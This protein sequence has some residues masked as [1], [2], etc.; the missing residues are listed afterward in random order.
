MSTS[1]STS[2]R[3]LQ[4][5]YIPTE[6]I[7][8]MYLALF[9][10]S[11]FAHTVQAFYFRLW[12]LM[13]SVIFC[14]FLELT[15]WS[16]RLWSSQ[17]PFLDKPYIMQ[18]VT[19]VIAPTPLVAA[20]FILLGRIIRRL[21]PQYSR[22]TPRR[23]TIIF[24]S[25]DIISLVIQALGGGIAS[26]S[27]SRSQAQAGSHIALGGTVFQLVAIIAYCALAAEFLFRYTRDRPMRSARVPG[28][29]LRGMIDKRLR[30]MLIAMFIMTD[31]I[32]IR[33][34]YRTVEFVDGWDGKVISTQWLF[35]VFDGAMIVLAMFTLNA[36][37]PGVLLL[38]SDDLNLY[39]TSSNVITL[40][41]H[42]SKNGDSSEERSA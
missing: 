6:W 24:V 7:S 3:I 25:C 38:G 22:L 42:L 39:P 14:G 13:P 2:D 28:E 9:G 37:H 33:T 19:L 35:N 8:I 40:R 18:A 36:F 10:L 21:G 12:W 26:V 27:T 17:N 20:N 15:G 23:Y 29:A 16:S 1:N 32:V 34:V 31:F 30:R 5:N 11:T 41:D 4:Y